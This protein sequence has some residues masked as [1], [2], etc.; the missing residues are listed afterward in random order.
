MFEKL[1]SITKYYTEKGS[2]FEGDANRFTLKCQLL[3]LL[4]LLLMWVLNQIDIFIIDK[5]IMTTAI[6]ACSLIEVIIVIIYHIFGYDKLWMKY[7]VLFFSVMMYTVAGIYLTYHAIFAS[8]LPLMYSMQYQRKKVVY[9]TYI[10][11]IFSMIAIVLGGYYLGICD[12]NMVLLTRTGIWEYI[13]AGTGQ[14]VLTTVNESPLTTLLLFYV[15]P[16]MVMLSATIPVMQYIVDTI[17]KNAS[18]QAEL[19]QLSE[20]DQMTHLFNRNKYN[21]MIE[22]YFPEIDNVAVIF[23]DINGLKTLNDTVGHDAGDYMIT[24]IAK[25]IF[26]ITGSNRYAFRIG[27]DEFVMIIE[28]PKDEEIIALLD[29]WNK[30]MDK[31]NNSSKIYLSASVGYSL[32]KGKDIKQLIKQADNMMYDEKRKMKAQNNY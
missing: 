26:K 21:Q 9:Y 10:L 12:A 19:K 15:L 32:G 30:N 27:G 18:V 5:E 2:S 4:L 7:V 13:D 28:N 16:R 8:V 20:I 25:T 14:F 24:L 17:T 3:S 23:W 6:V 29:E 11:T 1:K 22:E 31:M